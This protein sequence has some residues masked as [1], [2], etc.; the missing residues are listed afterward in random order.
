VKSERRSI[1][2]S[3]SARAT[4]AVSGRKSACVDIRPSLMTD[5]LVTSLLTLGF[6]RV[7]LKF[8]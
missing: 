7:L 1:Y 3:V 8:Y 5:V 2:S 4:G 6:V